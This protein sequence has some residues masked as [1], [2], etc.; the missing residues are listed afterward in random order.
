MEIHGH[1]S[2]HRYCQCR[3]SHCGTGSKY[4]Q[5]ALLKSAYFVVQFPE[6]AW[7]TRRIVSRRLCLF[8]FVY[9]LPKQDI[10]AQNIGIE[11]AVVYFEELGLRFVQQIQHVVRLVVRIPQR[12]RRNAYQFSLNEFL[13][14]QTHMIFYVCRRSDT[15]GQ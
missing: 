15:G 8:Y 4:N 10:H 12:F 14:K 13:R 1:V 2:R 7:Q 11:V 5:R 3:L 9:R 6:P